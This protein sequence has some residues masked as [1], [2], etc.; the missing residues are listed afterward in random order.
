MMQAT[1][2]RNKNIAAI[3]LACGMTFAIAAAQE[4]IAPT[5]EELPAPNP[6][7][8]SSGGLQSVL[9]PSDT[10]GNTIPS[11][12]PPAP[13]PS[14]EASATPLAPNAEG[15]VQTLP[16]GPIHEAFATAPTASFAGDVAPY[17]PPE[18]IQE[19]PAVALPNSSN[20][21]WIPGYWHWDTQQQQYIWV[22]GLYRVAPPGRT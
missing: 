22:S 20:A 14:P 18:V 4:T 8:S 12:V 13:R 17:A 15:A 6:T 10:P 16:Q 21:T 11:Q 7:E 9:E 5:L 1:L 3:A 2:I 19:D